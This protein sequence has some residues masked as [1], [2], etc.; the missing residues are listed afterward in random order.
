MAYRWDEAKDQILQKE[1]NIS[2][3]DAVT[4]INDG[5]VLADLAH[6]N[7]AVYA[8]QRVLIV[9]IGGYAYIVPYVIEADGTRFLK[10]MYPS[11]AATKNFLSNE[12]Q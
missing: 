11:R 6:A 4:A 5:G 10:T 3:L 8:H 7:T 2:F 12:Q 1:R 9:E